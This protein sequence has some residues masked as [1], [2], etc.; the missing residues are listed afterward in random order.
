MTSSLPSQL[1]AFISCT[2]PLTVPSTFAR[3]VFPAPRALWGHVSVIY[4]LGGGLGEREKGI[5]G[6]G[7]VSGAKQSDGGAVTDEEGTKFSCSLFNYDIIPRKFFQLLLVMRSS[8][9]IWT[10]FYDQVTGE[11]CS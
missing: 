4:S 3:H 11:I 8:P 6:W 10:A 7:H 9:R 2:V 1:S 5:G